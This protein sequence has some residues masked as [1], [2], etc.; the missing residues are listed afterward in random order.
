M[1]IKIFVTDWF[2]YSKL[3]I[4]FGKDRTKLILFVSQHKIKNV[5]KT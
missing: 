5:K 1:I 3:S 2:V 4:H